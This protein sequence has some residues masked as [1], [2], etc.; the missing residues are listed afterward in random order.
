MYTTIIFNMKYILFLIS[1]FFFLSVYGQNDTNV[2]TRNI[3][4]GFDK[5][6]FIVFDSEID[7]FDV[8]SE[9]LLFEITAKPNIVK[10]KGAVESFAE[11]NVTIITK[12]G[13]YY[14][15]IVEYNSSPKLL[16]HILTTNGTAIL[17][18]KEEVKEEKEQSNL[19]KD[20]DYVEK[21]I[22]SDPQRLTHSIYEYKM[23]LAVTGIY[24]YKGNI[25]FNIVVSNRSSIDYKVETL[26][27]SVQPRRKSKRNT[28]IQDVYIQ[29]IHSKNLPSE[30][31]ANQEVNNILVC[32]EPFTIPND[33]VFDIQIVETEGS[34]TL[35]VKLQSRNILSAKIIK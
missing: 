19:L 25:Y 30:I 6:T 26:M 7:F 33:K 29:P 21:K 20:F 22:S 13:Q 14:S 23:G 1:T 12:K 11:T 8:G 4:V 16:N 9:D 18:D 27:F 5:T 35:D 32:F 10:L 24:V 31:L 17:I 3:Q 2:I 28:T 34:R 15:F